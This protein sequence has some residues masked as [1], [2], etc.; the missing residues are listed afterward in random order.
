MNPY[1]RACL[2][3]GIAASLV[4]AA[5]PP[6]SRKTPNET[7]EQKR[8]A[9]LIV[10]LGDDAYPKREAASKELKTIGVPAFAALHRATSS[11]DLEVRRRAAELMRA[12][13]AR[14]EVRAFSGHN[15]GVVAVALSPDG[16]LALSGPVCYTSKDSAARL[17]DI[18]TGKQLRRLEAHTAGV[19]AV[20]FSPDSKRAITAGGNDICLWDVASGK[21]LRRLVGH[22]D[23]IYAA[24]FSPDGKSI[25]SGGRDRTVRLWDAKT[26]KERKRFVG[27]TGVVRAV[28]FAPDGKRVLSRSIFTGAGC[29]LWDVKNG[30]NLLHFPSATNRTGSPGTAG[31]AF[32]PDGKLIAVGGQDNTVRLV[33]ARTGKEVRRLIGHGGEVGPVVFTSDSKRLLSGSE[34]RT[35]CLWDVQSGKEL[36]RLR[37]HTQRVWS[38]VCS[39]DGRYALSGSFDRTMRLWHLPR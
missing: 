3:L 10:Q 35:I 27:H 15:D 24:V 39:R 8:I 31:I 33:D 28:A 37:G 34:D 6:G 36:C 1:L 11:A 30:K 23:G 16:K 17:W 2:L 25:L 5:A 22:S 7:A 19:Y 32:S 26:G 12:I 29:R 4:L 13:A 14:L 18:A 20:A 9:R 21:Q 38:I